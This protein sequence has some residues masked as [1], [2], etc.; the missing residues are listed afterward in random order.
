VDDVL[1]LHSFG[2]PYAIVTRRREDE[3]LV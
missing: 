1:R 2:L 3:E